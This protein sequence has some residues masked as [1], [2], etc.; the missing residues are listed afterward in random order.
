M[1]RKQSFETHHLGMLRSMLLLAVAKRVAL[2]K[3]MRRIALRGLF[4]ERGKRQA[5]AGSIPDEHDVFV[6]SG[7]S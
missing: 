4:S 3:P 2:V 7:A 1:A 6:A 5:F